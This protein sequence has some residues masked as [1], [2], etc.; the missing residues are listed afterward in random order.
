MKQKEGK[1]EIFLKALRHEVYAAVWLR[2]SEIP[3]LPSIHHV[4]V[5]GK[6]SL[7]YVSPGLVT[8]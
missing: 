6:I 1:K 7:A 2:V 8:G 4:Y 5:A 3:V